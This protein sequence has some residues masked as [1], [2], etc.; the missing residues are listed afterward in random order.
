MFGVGVNSDSGL[1]GNIVIDEQNFDLFRWPTKLDDWRN[2][3]AFRGAGQQFRLEALPGTEL[4]R[5]SM[6]FAE[7][8]LFNS[9]VSFGLSAFYYE[10]QYLNW[11]ERRWGART[12]LGYIFPEKPRPLDHIFD[13]IRRDQYPR[14][15]GSHTTG[16]AG[17]GGRE[18]VDCVSL[19]R[20]A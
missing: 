6:S 12:S 7:P 4:Q 15:H 20:D 11:D 8:Y 2:G 5:Y 3:T 19:G 13:A 18:S 16:L 17:G 9:S 14:S 10:R 1:L